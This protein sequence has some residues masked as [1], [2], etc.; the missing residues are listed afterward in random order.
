MVRKLIL[1][2]I[3]VF[4]LIHLIRL[5]MWMP[6]GNP[7]AGDAITHWL[8]MSSS[9]KNF[10]F[11]PWSLITYMFAHEGVLHILFNM[12]WLYFLGNL[13]TEYL[14]HRK[15]LLVYF[16]GG[17]AG[18][19]FYLLGMNV[20][21]PLRNS[22]SFNLPMLGASAAVM[23]VVVAIATLLPNYAIRL[24]GIIDIK[25]KYLA[26]FYI[27][28][29]VL[30]IMGSNAGGNLAH[31][32]GIFF[33]FFYIRQIRHYSFLDRWSDVINGWVNKIYRRKKDEKSIYRSY[34][35]Y[36]KEEDNT[37]PDQEEIDAILDKINRSGYDS[38][39]KKEKEKLF[40]A[41]KNN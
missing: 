16:W 29:S 9:L 15:L 13:F 34:T 26:F 11:K 28:L 17:I 37:I 31:L 36:M 6:S 25:L 38:L 4:L 12:L 23:A 19:L 40:K 1:I 14:G 32:G 10:I 8:Y 3:G 41:S 21:P 7:N 20:I 35:V 24:F 5:V 18:G 22:F 39:T 2:N 27:V 33:G 30:G